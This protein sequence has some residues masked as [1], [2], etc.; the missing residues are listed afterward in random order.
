MRVE[1]QTCDEAT[2][3]GA[4]TEIVCSPPLPPLTVNL[5]DRMD[6][7][8]TPR[9]PRRTREKGGV[10]ARPSNDQDSTHVRERRLHA[11]AV[12]KLGAGWSFA[13]CILTV[14][15][16]T[17]L[18]ERIGVWGFRDGVAG[19]RF[20]VAS[21]EDC[22][23]EEY[24]IMVRLQSSDTF[25]RMSLGVVHAP[26]KGTF[27][28]PG[29]EDDLD[30]DDGSDKENR[31][32]L[33]DPRLGH[34]I[35]IVAI[36][37]KDCTGNLGSLVSA[38]HVSE[39]IRK[40]AGWC[41]SL[42]EGSVIPS[43]FGVLRSKPYVEARQEATEPNCSEKAWLRA[44]MELDSTIETPWSLANLLT[45][46]QISNASR[47]AATSAPKSCKELTSD[48]FLV[49][50]TLALSTNVDSCVYSASRKSEKSNSIPTAHVWD[51]VVMRGHD[52][53]ERFCLVSCVA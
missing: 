17:G 30:L 19:K 47:L 21:S 32:P 34:V 48:L 5:Y 12:A 49:M 28:F 15:H 33:V 20:M 23:R 1:G 26:S 18:A 36:E 3:S 38:S 24:Y 16:L 52:D 35:R 40:Q 29:H 4:V 31:V 37:D 39:V 42:P 46:D 9:P 25:V 51:A 13:E 7:E 50:E 6:T 8:P 22:R 53:C 44:M 10:K 27:A 43:T 2:W 14:S 41:D 11:R 45:D